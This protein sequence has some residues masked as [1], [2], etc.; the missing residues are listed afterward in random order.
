MK[1]SPLDRLI[2][3]TSSWGSRITKSEGLKLL[4]QYI[5]AGVTRIDTA[6]P[7]GLGLAE[8]F[9]AEYLDGRHVP[10]IDV[11]T[12]CGI[13]RPPGGKVRGRIMP[14]IY[15]A[16]RA[17]PTVSKLIDYVRRDREIIAPV[18]I[19]F[20]E[21]DRSLLESTTFL[22][23]AA[24]VRVCF[25]DIHVTPENLDDLLV[26]SENIKARFGLAAV[27]FSSTVR[28]SYEFSDEF[29]FVN[30]D[31]EMLLHTEGLRCSEICVYS[32][33]AS[34]SK[35]RVT[36]TDLVFD[37]IERGYAV[38]LNPFGKQGRQSFERILEN[39]A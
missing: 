4:D 33:M 16:S 15:R 5:G 24:A 38:I 30:I 14:L 31:Y 6:P 39:V 34:A 32:V 11:T 23:G 13:G 26:F 27:G 20:T 29:D 7:Y 25:H 17:S 3:G 35:R 9:L 2:I 8:V 28:D 36:P 12:K 10:G 1:S 18:N 19:R 21:W 22:Q 37:A